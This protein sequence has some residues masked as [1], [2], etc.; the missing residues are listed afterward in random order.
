MVQ[1]MLAN[2]GA[3]SDREIELRFM[4][5]ETGTIITLLHLLKKI[6]RKENF[7]NLIRNYFLFCWAVK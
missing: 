5:E 4:T 2:A 1:F 3:L 6:G 7:L